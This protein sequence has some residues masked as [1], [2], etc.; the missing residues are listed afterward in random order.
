MTLF[1]CLVS[2]VVPLYYVAI[3]AAGVPSPWSTLF[4]LPSDFLGFDVSPPR[5]IVPLLRVTI[6]GLLEGLIAFGLGKRFIFRWVPVLLVSIVTAL[7]CRRLSSGLFDPPLPVVPAGFGVVAAFSFFGAV[8]AVFLFLDSC[9]AER[10]EE[11]G[12]H[13]GLDPSLHSG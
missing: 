8:T 3:F 7:A 6:L 4:D 9:H 1:L 10:S 12:S 11:S 5:V 13:A 2:A